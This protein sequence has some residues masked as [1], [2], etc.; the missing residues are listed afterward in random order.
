M[1][2]KDTP[3]PGGRDLFT[4]EGVVVPASQ[5]HRHH[6]RPLSSGSSVILK[7]SCLLEMTEQLSGFALRTISAE[8]GVLVAP[9][10]CGGT[11]LQC[12]DY[13]LSPLTR[14]WRHFFNPLLNI[15]HTIFLSTYH[16]NTQQIF[17]PCL[18]LPLGHSGVW[19]W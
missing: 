13:P 12:D 3:R 14:R 2:L 4:T 11:Q 10:P 18:L 5:H 7:R 19:C 8:V 6:H 16:T 17:P 1:H 15:Q 9:G